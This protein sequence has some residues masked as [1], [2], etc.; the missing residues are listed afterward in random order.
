[1]MRNSI[2]APAANHDVI[3][4]GGGIAGS[5]VAAALDNFGYRILIVEP[6]LDH[7]K[8]LAG[9]LIHPSGVD[10]LSQL[11]LV[12]PLM[13]AG[14]GRIRGFAL[15]TG[16]GTNKPTHVLPYSDS[17]DAGSDGFAIE[18]GVMVRALLEHV[19]TLPNVT[20]WSASR[21][22][23]LDA[24]SAGAVS[25]TIEHAHGRDRLSAAL[26]VAAD[27][28][29]S[30][31][32]TMA[33]IPHR[34]TH[35]SNM[36][37]YMLHGNELPQANFGHVF[38]AGSA[39]VLAY[40]VGRSETRI[41]FDRPP[42][43]NDD[44]LHA[45]PPTLRENAVRAIETQPP[46]RSANVSITPAAVFKGRT[47]CVGDAG[48]CCHPLTA[49]GLSACTRDALLLRQALRETE[50]NIPEAL[51]RYARR[52]AG[53]ERTRMAGADLLYAAFRAQTPE[54]RL[55][56]Q[57]LFRYWDRSPAG[58]ITTMALLSM[59]EERLASLVREYAQICRHSVPELMNMDTRGRAMLGLSRELVRFVGHA[60]VDSLMTAAK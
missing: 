19:A 41:M 3:I 21:V 16:S 1:M 47:V 26:L 49:T 11:G 37:G 42:D 48:G 34:Q 56:R 38:I 22:T 60:C 33:G 52:R 59:Q 15:F 32:R 10:H 58:R 14:G 24:D 29:T 39:P 31:V 50:Q 30:H 23:A 51:Q 7:A 25:V 54:M 55:L 2:A 40:S 57:G 20:V 17:C 8:R 53:P 46:L 12:N 18:H 44:C 35:I 45:L 28:R 13:A 4:A 27:G 36:I 9:E 5:S 43:S 6:G